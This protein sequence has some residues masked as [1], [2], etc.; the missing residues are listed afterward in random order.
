[1]RFEK[2]A[3]TVSYGVHADDLFVTLRRCSGRRAG[4][5]GG[6]ARAQRADRARADRHMGPAG[7]ARDVLAGLRRECG[8]IGG[9]ADP[10]HPVLARCGRVDGSRFAH[11]VVAPVAGNRHRRVRPRAGVRARRGQA[12]AGRD[13]A[14]GAAAVAS[15]ERALAAAC[16]GQLRAQRVRRALRRARSRASVDDGLGAALQQ[17]QDRRLRAGSQ[18]VSGRAGRVRDRGLQ[19]RHAVQRR[20]ATCAT[21]CPPA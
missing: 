14:H 16:R 12:E 8:G 17:P 3:P 20:V 18:G 5:S 19:E 9:R 7:H 13:A 2:K 15:D 11:P 1:M 10:R 6:R 21:L 4:R